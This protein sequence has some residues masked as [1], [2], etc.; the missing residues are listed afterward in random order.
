MKHT[1]EQKFVALYNSTPTL[2][3]RSPGR[4]NLIGEHID[5]NDGFVMPAAI[6]RSIVFA[7]AKNSSQKVN[8]YS[9]DFNQ[10]IVINLQKPFARQGNWSDYLVGVLDQFLKVNKSIAG[11][12]LVFGGDIPL[13]AG[14]SS[15]A[16]VECGL[17][18]SLNQLFDLQLS[19]LELVQLSQKA[20]NNFVGINCGIMDQFASMFGQSSAVIQLDCRSLAYQY[21][22]FL[23]H[24][25]VLILCDTTVKHSLG[26]SEYNQRRQE[27]EAGLAI[28]KAEFT[29]I[30]SFRD[31]TFEQLQICKNKL[32]P[33]S[34]HRCQYVIAEIQ[35]VQKACIA[36]KNNDMAAFGQ[37]MYQTHEGL[38]NK[39]KVSCP[40]LDF[41]ISHT[42]TIPQ[43][44][45]ARM[46]GGGFGGCTINLVEAPFAKQFIANIQAAYLAKYQ[47]KL[48]CHQVTI[49]AGTSLI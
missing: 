47:K 33:N 6:D 12:D 23:Q 24:N 9:L 28:L 20:E 40:E 48:P 7:V 34:Y 3:V 19:T 45:G 11:F 13:G 21:I 5:Y 43:V 27:C 38:Q 8:L 42:K 31:V 35:R 18:F 41:L 17:A 15:S 46:M 2:F 26:D 36:L 30:K 16:A 1:I 10:T 49:T 44:L 4:I 22:P 32:S 25:H 29:Q 37:F 39:Y 14:L